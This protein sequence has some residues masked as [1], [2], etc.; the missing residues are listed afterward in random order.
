MQCFPLGL[1][2][3]EDN[4]SEWKQLM[5]AASSRILRLLLPHKTLV[6]AGLQGDITGAVWN[7]MSWRHGDRFSRV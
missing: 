5:C 3:E 7:L 4:Q 6:S 2:N 1:E